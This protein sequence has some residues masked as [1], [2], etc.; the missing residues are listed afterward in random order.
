MG[1]FCRRVFILVMYLFMDVY[2]DNDLNLIYVGIVVFKVCIM[3]F[4][5]FV[6]F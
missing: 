6:R 1:K 2:I 3:L 5:F 4:G